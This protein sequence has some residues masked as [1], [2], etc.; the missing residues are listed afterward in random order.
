MAIGRAAAKRGP[1]VTA[2]P[3]RKLLPEMRDDFGVVIDPEMM[4]LHYR[5][6]YLEK[7]RTTTILTD[8]D[9]INIFNNYEDEE[10]RIS[11]MEYVNNNKEDDDG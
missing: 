11:E 1:A 5:L 3:V 6:K 2:A 4:L 7:F 10:N 9:M 8:E